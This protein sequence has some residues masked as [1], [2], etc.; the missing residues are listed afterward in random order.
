MLRHRSRG[1]VSDARRDLDSVKAMY[2]KLVEDGETLD[3]GFIQHYNH[4]LIKNSRAINEPSHT[5]ST[6]Q[7]TRVRPQVFPS[8]ELQD[9]GDSFHNL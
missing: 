8:I 4:I 2:N 7:V 5:G 1:Y 3:E 9:G 6:I